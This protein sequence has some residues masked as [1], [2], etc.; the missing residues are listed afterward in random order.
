M[1]QVYRA[2][3]NKPWPKWELL[4]TLKGNLPTVEAN[5]WT[6][7]KQCSISSRAFNVKPLTLCTPVND[8]ITGKKEGSSHK[9]CQQ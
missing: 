3:S 4:P 5:K 6:Y 1:W 8:R 2:W 9:Y 7:S